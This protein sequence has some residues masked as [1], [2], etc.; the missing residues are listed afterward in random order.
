MDLTHLSTIL[1]QA[2]PAAPAAPN[3]IGSLVPMVLLVI[4][5]YFLLI[6]P[7]QKKSK[8]HARMLKTIKSGDKV[9]T[10]GG[11]IASVV[12]VKE[13]SVSIRSAD[14]KIEVTKSAIAEI[15]ERS[16][17]SSES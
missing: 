5:F 15:V 14:A 11:I 4:I 17:E 1:A 2:T 6:R 10:N 3:I 13:K 12:T 8:E 16:G 7:Q 9:V